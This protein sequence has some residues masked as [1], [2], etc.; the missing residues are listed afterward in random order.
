MLQFHVKHGHGPSALKYHGGS[1]Q[2]AEKLLGHKQANKQKHVNIY[3][4]STL[5]CMENSV[6]SFTKFTAWDI[7][8]YEK[9]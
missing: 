3:I 7:T 8:T 4:R 9:G 5:V 6:V 1:P 2:I